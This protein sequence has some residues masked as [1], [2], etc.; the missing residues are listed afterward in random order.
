MKH[1]QR[2]NPA[3]DEMKLQTKL[4]VRQCEWKS[5]DGNHRLMIVDIKEEVVSTEKLRLFCF[6]N[7]FDVIKIAE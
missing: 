2:L 1:L 5:K 6:V 4:F 3:E 7:R